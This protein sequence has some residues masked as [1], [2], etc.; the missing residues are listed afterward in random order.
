MQHEKKRKK[1]TREANN[2]NA[3]CNSQQIIPIPTLIL[4]NLVIVADP[5]R[6]HHHAALLVGFWVQHVVAFGAEVKRGLAAVSM[7]Q[8]AS[9]R[10]YSPY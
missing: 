9:A 3:L 7:A 10:P 4:P 2:K 5:T 6:E 1:T 8:A